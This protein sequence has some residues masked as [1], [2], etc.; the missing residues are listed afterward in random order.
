MHIHE[1]EWSV[2]EWR[3]Y[4]EQCR[5]KHNTKNNNKQSCN[6]HNT[7]NCAHREIYSVNMFCVCKKSILGLWV[8]F[9]IVMKNKM[10]SGGEGLNST[11]FSVQSGPVQSSPARGVEGFLS[12][13][14]IKLQRDSLFPK[15]LPTLM[16]Q[17]FL[18]QSLLFS[19]RKKR[20]KLVCSVL[21]NPTTFLYLLIHPH[22]S[23]ICALL[24]DQDRFDSVI[25]F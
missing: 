4:K 1:W 6:E 16:L 21:L 7:M 22:S 10:S 24:A 20:T 12:A 25:V 23:V 19:G 9:R 13:K 2:C 14:M 18:C 3:K 11:L 15:P 5:R 8:F 17:L